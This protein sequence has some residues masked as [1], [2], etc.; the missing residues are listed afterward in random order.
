MP[1]KVPSALV[2]SGIAAP[3]IYVIFSSRVTNTFTKDR[4]LPK[5]MRPMTAFGRIA[6]LAVLLL[7]ASRTAF[8]APRVRDVWHAYVADGKRYGA[9]HTVVVRLHSPLWDTLV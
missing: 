6:L 8:G 1:G 5:E 4:P 3:S 7:P 2:V 9:V